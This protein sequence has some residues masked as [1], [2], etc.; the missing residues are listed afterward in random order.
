MSNIKT[1]KFYFI[2]DC[3]KK[4]Q[5]KIKKNSNIGIVMHYNE[6]NILNTINKIKN[7]NYNNKLYVANNHKHITNYKIEGVYLSAYNKNIKNYQN[8]CGYNYPIIGSA[9]SFKEIFQKIRA[10]CSIIFLSN[11]FKTQ[12]HPERE[13]NIGLLKFLL[14]QKQIRKV[15]IYAMGGITKRNY[16]TLNSIN[17]NIGYGGISS[18]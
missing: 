12:S 11:V 17:K 1:Q 9:H 3:N 6:Y 2:E 7:I 15:S 18:F 8:I 13:T 14:I 4:T 10:G 5:D 16:I